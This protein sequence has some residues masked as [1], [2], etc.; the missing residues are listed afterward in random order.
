MDKRVRAL[1][2]TLLSALSF[3]IAFVTVITFLELISMATWY[4]LK[5]IAF[6]AILVG[7]LVSVYIRRYR[8]LQE[9]EAENDDRRLKVVRSDDRL[10]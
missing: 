9:N 8:T 10:D 7:L 2:D 4:P 3:A 6:G 5:W 1:V